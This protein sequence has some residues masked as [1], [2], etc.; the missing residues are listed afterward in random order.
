MYVDQSDVIIAHFNALNEVN[1]KVALM[2]F[3]SK[4]I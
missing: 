2:R 1:I 4:Q 3:K